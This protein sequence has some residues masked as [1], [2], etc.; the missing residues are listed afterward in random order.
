MRNIKL[1]DFDKALNN[2]MQDD[3]FKREYEAIEGEFSLASEVIKLRLEQNLT[4]K[5]LAAR[6]GTSQPAIARL[7]SGR[8][9]GVS[10]SF[11]KRI[12][13]ALNALPT[14]HLVKTA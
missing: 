10:L 11:L 8:Y 9:E 4:Q 14:I 5:E 3:E 12:G 7:E 6:A 2:A 1:R 13:K